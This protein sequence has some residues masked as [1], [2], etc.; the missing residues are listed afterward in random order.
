MKTK[1]LTL[2]LGVILFAAGIAVLWPSSHSAVG[3]QAAGEA[4]TGTSAPAEPQ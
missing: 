4:E 1:A 2:V 3:Q